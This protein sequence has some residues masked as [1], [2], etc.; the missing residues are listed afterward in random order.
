MLQ[1][2][3]DVINLAEHETS[4]ILQLLCFSYGQTELEISQQRQASSVGRHTMKD[5]QSTIL[6]FDNW[7]RPWMFYEFIS[8]DK[9]LSSTDLE[10]FKEIWTKA[11]DFE[12]WNFSDLTLGCKAAHKCIKDNFSLTDET[13]AKIVRA[14]SY[15]WK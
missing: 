13:V 5:L 3:L 1:F 6:S 2:G 12:L 8:Y 7:T 15:Q 14:I 10:L 11:S 9:E 4:A